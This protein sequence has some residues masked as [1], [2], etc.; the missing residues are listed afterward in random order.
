M[1]GTERTGGSRTLLTSRHVL[2][3]VVIAL[4]SRD[5]GAQASPRVAPGARVYSDI[6]RLAG[7]G[8]IDTIGYGARPFSQREIVRLHHHH[9][10]KGH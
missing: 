5:V 1:P 8:L 4:T 9:V 6:D 7:A 2:V 10:R 3:A